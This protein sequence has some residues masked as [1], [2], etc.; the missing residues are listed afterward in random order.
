[1]QNATGMLLCQYAIKSSECPESRGPTACALKPIAQ[2]SA[3]RR[4]RRRSA[5]LCSGLAAGRS[6]FRCLAELGR[7]NSRDCQH[8]SSYSMGNPSEFV[9]DER[10]KLQAMTRALLPA[11]SSIAVL[12]RA[13]IPMQHLSIGFSQCVA[14]STNVTNQGDDGQSCHA[15]LST[16]YLGVT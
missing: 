8:T 5:H 10:S 1:M 14:L 13:E 7:P 3:S 2:R 15:L 9:L 11:P 12:G 16:R 6:A 4:L